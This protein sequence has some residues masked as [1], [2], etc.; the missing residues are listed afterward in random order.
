LFSTAKAIVQILSKKKVQGAGPPADHA[1]LDGRNSLAGAAAMMSAIV[2][3]TASAQAAPC[4]Q[5]GFDGDFP[6]GQANH[7]QVFVT[8]TGPTNVGVGLSK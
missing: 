1:G 6:I 5:S 2:L 7:W 4:S 3:L 8:S